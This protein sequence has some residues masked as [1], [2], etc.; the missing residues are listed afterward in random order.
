MPRPRGG[1]KRL[2]VLEA[3]GDVFVTGEQGDVL[4]GKPYDGR[5][6][7]QPVVNRACVANGFTA[8]RIRIDLRNR[9][10]HALHRCGNAAIDVQ[11]LAID[12]RS[13]GAE[14]EGAR[15]GIVF[16]AT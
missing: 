12:E 14:K 8:E 2:P 10:A 5:E 7:A 6:L 4:T 11:N 13:L 1:R 9:L 3:T 15:C 16:L